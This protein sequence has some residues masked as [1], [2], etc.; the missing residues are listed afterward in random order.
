MTMKSS[1]LARIARL[2][3][4]ENPWDAQSNLDG[5]T[6]YLAALLKEF[7]DARMALVAYN[8]GPE[9]VRW[10]REPPIVSE[11]YAQKVLRTFRR[12]ARMW[13]RAF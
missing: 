2:P 8:A 12:L 4:V 6:R 10:G 9:V 3:R 5:G 11:R 1:L 13:E 7:G